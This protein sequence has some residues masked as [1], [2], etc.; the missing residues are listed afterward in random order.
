MH[1]CQRV[2][3]CV[4]LVMIS[5]H[6]DCRYKDWQQFISCGVAAKVLGKEGDDDF[7]IQKIDC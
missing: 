7:H 6:N 3:N 2:P 1:W 5:V 4:G